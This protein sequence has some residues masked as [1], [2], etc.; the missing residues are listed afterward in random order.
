MTISRRKVFGLLAATAGI[1]AIPSSLL[2]LTRP[3]F[4]L[5][6]PYAGYMPDLERSKDHPDYGLPKME[7]GIY[8]FWITAKNV[9]TGFHESARFR[10]SR[11]DLLGYWW[12]RLDSG[13][14]RV[15]EDAV[16]RYFERKYA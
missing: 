11:T 1:H 8:P 4:I 14:W 9:A 7:G 13:G 6:G 3:V 10:L 5:Y 2:A 16:I 15:D 12:K